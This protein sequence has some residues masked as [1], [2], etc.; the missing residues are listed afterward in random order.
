MEVGTKKPEAEAQDESERERLREA[1][2]GG[3]K[4]ATLPGDA[5]DASG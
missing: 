1:H 2:V 5:L 3:E 4:A